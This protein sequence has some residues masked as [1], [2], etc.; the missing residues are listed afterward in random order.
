M[1]TERSAEAHGQY[2]D[3]QVYPLPTGWTAAHVSVLQVA[4][5]KA[6]E[7]LGES[8]GAVERL[9][10]YYDPTGDYAGALM[11]T[12][13]PNLGDE[14]TAADLWAVSTLSIQVPPR[15]G[16]LLL[17][18]G[19]R[20]VAVH[21]HLAHIR[22]GLSIAALHA[23]DDEV[24]GALDAMWGLQDELKS[25]LSDETPATNR[26]VFASKLC[27][28][29]R[30]RLFPVRDNLVCA[31]LSETGRLKPGVGMSNFDNDI[32]VFGYLMS[33]PEITNRLAQLRRELDPDGLRLDDTD[34]RLLDVIL[35]T[36]AKAGQG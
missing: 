11:T 7:A 4:R 23:Q 16:R 10:A 8:S 32:Q 35:W 27:A 36:A 25:L 14:V 24:R 3:G 15:T 33:C 20:R 13:E 12:V 30:P 31:Y 2:A 26:W 1:P 34:L 28:R 17:D 6:N 19:P 21:G 18:S 22:T 5:E 9:R 29:K